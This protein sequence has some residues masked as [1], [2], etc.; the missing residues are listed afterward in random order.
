[1]NTARSK[2]K[3]MPVEAAQSIAASLTKFVA[4]MGK[5]MT[6]E[7]PEMLRELFYLA[8]NITRLELALFHIIETNNACFHP[9]KDHKVEFRLLLNQQDSNPDKQIWLVICGS[10]TSVVYEGINGTVI[11]PRRVMLISKQE[12][13]RLYCAGLS[14]PVLDHDVILQYATNISDKLLIC[15]EYE[16]N[17]INH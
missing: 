8:L 2:K 11:A 16:T 5:E 4:T 12:N 7:H 6:M 1:M 9:T 14:V 13:Y 15:T 3:T 10:F 17:P